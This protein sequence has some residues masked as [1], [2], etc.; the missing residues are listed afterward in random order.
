M[1]ETISGETRALALPTLLR[2]TIEAARDDAERRG[3][4]PDH[5]VAELRASGAFSLLT[6]AEYGGLEVPVTTALTVY[7]GLARIDPATAWVV[8]NANFGFTAAM[9]SEAGAARI[10]TGGGEPVL[11]NAG[12]PGSAVAVDG[13][14]R[15]SG[16]W[17]IVSGIEHAEWFVPLGVVLDGEQPAMTEAGKPDVRL[18]H[19]SRDQLKIERTWNVDGLRATGSHGVLVEDAF[20]PADLTANIDAP[21][22]LDRALYRLNPVLLVFAGCTAVALGTVGQAIDEL[23]ALAPGKPTAFGGLLAEQPRVQELLARH[24]TAV[25]AARLFLFDVTRRID[26]TARRGEP[27]TLDLH[28]DLHSAMAHAAA[29][30]REALVAMYQLGSSTSLYLGNPLERLHRDGMAAL[31]HVNQA[32][33]FFGG[34]GRVRLGLEP[35]LPLF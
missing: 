5:L 15:L 29:V 17:R 24:E 26:D 32:P 14:F 33:E 35:G 25:R 34:A 27:A 16:R 30:G 3:D 31:Q 2:G 10:W 19:V 4:L 8:W 6:P 21:L 18:F 22:R 23:V 9:L 12:Q 1:S 20:V 13:G 7:E 28:A 11:A